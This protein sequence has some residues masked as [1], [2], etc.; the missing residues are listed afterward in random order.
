MA[1]PFGISF[2][3]SDQNGPNGQVNGQ[4]PNPVQ[5]AI[6]TLSL[7]IPRVAGASAFTAQP[8][9]NSPGGGALGGDPNSASILEQLR[10]MLFGTP[11]GAPSAGGAGGLDAGANP[12]GSLAGLFGGIPDT[13][14]SAPQQAADRN[15]SGIPDPHFDPNALPRDPGG[16]AMPTATAPPPMPAPG[17]IGRDYA[18][19][20]RGGSRFL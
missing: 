19:P 13:T 8:L 2:S 16:P 18:P 3:P 9:L 10:R 14:A 1:D 20:D 5:Q 12:L 11:A 7:R 4:R 6:Q 17:P 15:P